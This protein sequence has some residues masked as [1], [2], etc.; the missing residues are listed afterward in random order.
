MSWAVSLFQEPLTPQ[1]HVDVKVFV[2]QDK[3]FKLIDVPPAAVN[4]G[5]SNFDEFD[6]LSWA[7]IK[8]LH[9]L[10]DQGI[11][12]HQIML[13]FTGGLKVTSV[14]AAAVTFNREIRTQYVHTTKLK[15]IGYDLLLTSTLTEGMGW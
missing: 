2:T 14:V 3:S 12:D 4:A 9:C 1:T 7:L 13:D 8:L 11:Q 10:K 5:G 6:E 15:V